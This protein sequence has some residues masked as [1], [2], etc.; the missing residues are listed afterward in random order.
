VLESGGLSEDVFV[1]VQVGEVEVVGSA[2]GTVCEEGE[3]HSWG[4]CGTRGVGDLVGL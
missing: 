3:G 2:C 1:G 4:Q